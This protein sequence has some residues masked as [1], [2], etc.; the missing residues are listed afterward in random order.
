LAREVNP[1]SAR[2][3][4]PAIVRGNELKTAPGLFGRCVRKAIEVETGARGL[5]GGLFI[6]NP[7][8]DV[9]DLC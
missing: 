4:I 5:S 6:G 3:S 7:F 8:T 9:P 1:V 2:V